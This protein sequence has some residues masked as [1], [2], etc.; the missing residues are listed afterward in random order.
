[1]DRHGQHWIAP[2]RQ[3]D[4]F[5]PTRIRYSPTELARYDSAMP[6][7]NPRCLLVIFGA[8][9]DLTQRKLIPAL[10]DLF[11][12]G[13]LP[14]GLGVLGISRSQL[15]ADGFRERCKDKCS[16]RNGHSEATW[17][18]FAQRLDYHAADAAK[19]SDWPRIGTELHRQ[20]ERWGTQGNVVFYLSVTPELYEPIIEN[21]GT[22]GLV[23]GGKAWCETQGTPAPRQRII[24]EKPFGSSLATAENLNRVIGRVFDDE[25]VFR[26]DHY[27]G[28]ETVQNLMVFRFANLLFE[29]LWNRRYVDN[30]QITAEETVGLEN[31]AGY[32]DGIFS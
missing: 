7:V 30:V 29:P 2:F 20:C 15:G 10:Y 14:E 32:Y 19:Q 21:I 11:L 26:I 16:T 25:D 8:S 28:K 27:L 9:G 3:P 6:D 18:S 24:V 5:P 1:M 4:L 17:S 12:A 22:A 13:I 23:K 31:R